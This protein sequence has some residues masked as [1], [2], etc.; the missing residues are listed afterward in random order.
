MFDGGAYLNLLC[1]VGMWMLEDGGGLVCIYVCAYHVTIN[2]NN[3]EIAEFMSSLCLCEMSLHK[4]MEKEE[5]K[6][7]TGRAGSYYVNIHS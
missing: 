1:V 4:M 5:R 3:N 7:K 6:I 2:N